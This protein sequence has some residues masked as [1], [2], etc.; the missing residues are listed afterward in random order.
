MES[1]RKLFGAFNPRLHP[2]LDAHFDD[3]FYPQMPLSTP[4]VSSKIWTDTPGSSKLLFWSTK[5][6]STLGDLARFGAWQIRKAR[7]A[8]DEEIK[9]LED[10]K[11]GRGLSRRF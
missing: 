4:S 2:L 5:D 6:A 1:N 10:W 7:W 8:V 11:I 9:L 3:I